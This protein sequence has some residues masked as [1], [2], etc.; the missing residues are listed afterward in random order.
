MFNRA[1]AFNQNIS[2]W[3][4]SKVTDMNRL[5]YYASSFNQDISS[6]C[7]VKIA[8]KTATFDFGTPA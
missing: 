8:S 5:F 7:V 4:T 6:W 3:D 1:S 2:S